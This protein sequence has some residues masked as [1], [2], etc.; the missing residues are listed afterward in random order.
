MNDEQ[1]LRF[2]LIAGLLIVPSV[3]IYHRIKSE[4]A[5]EPL[6]RRQEG[7]FI[8]ATLRPFGAAFWIGTIVWMINPA[9]MAWSSMPV[10]LWVRWGAVGVLASGVVLTVWTFRSL[11]TN[12]TDTVVT[13]QRHTL[14]LHGPYQWVRHPFYC[15]GLLL[16]LSISLITANW[17][18]LVTGAV[19]FGLLVMRTRTEEAN[20]IARFGDGYRRYMERTGRFVPRPPRRP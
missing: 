1:I 14:V 20:L 8:L 18:L 17:F 6:D 3:G 5:R 2:L 10:P 4:A 7:A 15:A 9:W 12:L 19:V 16:M 11:G 13:R